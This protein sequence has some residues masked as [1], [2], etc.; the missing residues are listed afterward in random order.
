MVYGNSNPAIYGF[1]TSE[2][3]APHGFSYDGLNYHGR[4]EKYGKGHRNTK[5]K[6]LLIIRAEV[7]NKDP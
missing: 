5:I 3:L 2:K 6:H 7:P 1:F 4:R